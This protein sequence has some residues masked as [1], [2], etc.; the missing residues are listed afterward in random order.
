M[1]RL[2]ILEE[3]AREA[4][5]S[6]TSPS[7]C[8]TLMKDILDKNGLEGEFQKEVCDILE[9]GRHKQRNLCILGSTNMAKTF[10][11][12]P[13]ALIYKTYTRPDGGSYQLE[14][15]LASEVVCLNDFEFDEDANKVVQL[16][17][18]EVT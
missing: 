15:L 1:T 3:C 10:L 14:A 13:L 18:L 17:V 5:C 4:V 7:L 8:Y 2:Q 6:C 11:L 12:K 9:A 16:G